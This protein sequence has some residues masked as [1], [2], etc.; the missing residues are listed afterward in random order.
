MDKSAIENLLAYLRISSVHPNIDYG[1]R[2]KS[3]QSFLLTNIVAEPCLDFL[4]K[5][6][7]E[8]GLDFAVYR[9][10]PDKPHAVLTWIG[11]EPTLPTII[12]NSHM[13]VV[14][15]FKEYWSHKPFDADVDENGVI[16]ARG[17]QDVKYLGVQYLEAIRRLKLR[18]FCPK[19][20]VHVT[21]VSEE[22]LAGQCGMKLFVKTPEFKALNAGFALD[23]GM[24]SADKI[25]LVIYEE[26]RNWKFKIRCPEMITCNDNFFAENGTAGEKVQRV[27]KN[28]YDF[29]SREGDV[30]EFVIT[31]DSRVPVQKFASYRALVK[32]WCKEAGDGVTIEDIVNDEPPPHTNLDASNIFWVAFKTAMDLM[33]IEIKPRVFPANADARFLRSVGVPTI[34]YSNLFNIEIR[35]HGHDE[36]LPSQEFLQ[37]IS[38]F[39]Q[40][41]P[42]ITSA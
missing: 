10:L 13:D 42:A 11:R 1:K 5:Q 35:A 6:A 27:L 20:T 17:V 34:G 9:P 3:T 31:F 26:K 21:F 14:P 4:R 29:R 22:E 36:Y 2:Y 8:I 37:G 23:E 18:G 41:I 7:E 40:I 39:E 33:G 24:P 19:R 38:R 30:K 32:T 28:F 12:L 15:V 16:Y 25:A